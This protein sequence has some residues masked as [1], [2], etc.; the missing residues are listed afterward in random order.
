MSRS[1]AFSHRWGICI[2]FTIFGVSHDGAQRA[3]ATMECH[4]S[5]VVPWF[6]VCILTSCFFLRLT[7]CLLCLILFVH[8]FAVYI[9][10]C[11]EC[12]L[13]YKVLTIYDSLRDSHISWA[14]F[15]RV[16]YIRSCINKTNGFDIF[17]LNAF[18]CALME[19][20]ALLLCMVLFF[21][22]SALFFINSFVVVVFSIQSSAW[23]RCKK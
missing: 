9:T 16:A 1:Q 18:L 13:V 8:H 10:V 20:C 5:S 3:L 22:H 21:K 6:F 14:L 12:A 17:T 4:W 2:W 11:V 19:N 15:Y 23:N 7:L